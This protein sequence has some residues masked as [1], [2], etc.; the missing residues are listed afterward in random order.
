MLPPLAP[1]SPNILPPPCPLLIHTLGKLCLVLNISLVSNRQEPQ[2]S[3]TCLAHIL[4]EVSSNR[5]SSCEAQ[6]IPMWVRKSEHLATTQLLKWQKFR[7]TCHREH[8][9]KHTQIPDSVSLA[10]FC[11]PSANLLID[12]QIIS[13]AKSFGDHMVYFTD[14]ETETQQF[15]DQPIV[16]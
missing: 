12:L 14:G 13:T 1:A 6:L 5:S 16:S 7:R 8:R 2:L 11:F 4:R 10:C 9:L 3:D 15:N